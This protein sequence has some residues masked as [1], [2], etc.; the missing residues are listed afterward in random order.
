MIHDNQK[1]IDSNNVSYN[2][3]KLIEYINNQINEV[4]EIQKEIEK[5]NKELI[6]IKRAQ[7]EEFIKLSIPYI[8]EYNKLLRPYYLDFIKS[9]YKKYNKKYYIN[10]KNNI[11]N[12]VFIKYDD[13]TKS[14]IYPNTF[15]YISFQD[16]L[17]TNKGIEYISPEIYIKTIPTHLFEHVRIDILTYFKIV[18][19]ELNNIEGENV[20]SGYIDNLIFYWKY[21]RTNINF[22]VNNYID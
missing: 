12:I 19:D 21:E 3:T 17:K 5:R 8:D 22:D 11:D 6:D 4:K 14:L 16:F 10:E 7:L 20:L 1:L 9:K 2:K 13:T 15:A 18:L